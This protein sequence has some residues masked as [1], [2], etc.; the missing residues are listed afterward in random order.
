MATQVRLSASPLISAP[1][2]NAYILSQQIQT[3]RAA[4]A[5][6]KNM[7]Q[8]NVHHAA[9]LGG[10]IA[11]KAITSKVSTAG[12]KA[13]TINAAVDGK[14]AAGKPTAVAKKPL[15]VVHQVQVQPN[16][17][18]I[19]KSTRTRSQS[20]KKNTVETA[21]VAAK[22]SAVHAEIAKGAKA[23]LVK[24]VKKPSTATVENDNGVKPA[25]VASK[26]RVVIKSSPKTRAAKAAA[27]SREQTSET[28]VELVQEK[29]EEVQ[30]APIMMAPVYP[31]GVDD[32]DA[33]DACDPMMLSEYV[34]EIFEYMKKLEVESMP[35]P[36]YME[37][38]KELKWSMRDILIDWLIDI[39]NKFRLLPETLYLTVNIIDRFLSLRVVSLVKLQLVGIT[40]MFIAAK[41]EEV[42]APSIKNFIYMA[43][44]GYTDEEIQRAE[45]YVL[46]VL[47]FNLQYPSSMSFLRRCSKAENY[48]IQTRTLAKYLMEISLVDHR[49]LDVLPSHVAAAGLFLARRMLEQGEWDSNL[50]FYS[51]Y[52][53]E[54]IQPVCIMMLEYLNKPCKHE[55]FFKK[56]ASKKFMKASVF[57]KEWMTKNT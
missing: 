47:E 24:V 55:A 3:R 8:E 19:V 27:A 35:N 34:V 4:A 9:T 1:S 50:A 42:I 18:K 51:G 57:V 49:F 7:D 44:N 10:K 32:L 26:N 48:N 11:A 13:S 37:S 40:S 23:D 45:R 5:L 12:L 33:E 28:G 14:I 43:D 20:A 56:Y 38:Q 46:S 6:A 29:V 15:A 16:N 52:S 25:A 22:A 54:E 17:T 41:Y 31:E 30:Q 2:A 53:E 39:H 21:K 36:N